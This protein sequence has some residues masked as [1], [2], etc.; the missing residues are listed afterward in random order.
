MKSNKARH[1]IGGLISIIVSIFGSIMLIKNGFN[2]RI[3]IGIVLLLI[4]GIIEIIVTFSK[5]EEKNRKNLMKEVDE[6][7]LLIIAKSAQLTVQIINIILFTTTM[8]SIVLYGFTKNN[9]FMII[10]V[11]LAVI[12]L[13]VF[14]ISLITQSY[15]EKKL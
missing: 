9:I 15:L 7:D 4:L 2:T 5:E 13:I 3:F 6:R 12:S 8:I 14:V 10:T 11:T 1:F